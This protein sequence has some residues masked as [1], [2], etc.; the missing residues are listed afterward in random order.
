MKKSTKSNARTAPKLSMK[1]KACIAPTFRPPPGLEGITLQ[2]PPGFEK[3]LPISASP[4]GVPKVSP[5]G[6][7]VVPKG[8]ENIADNTVQISNMPKHIAN[9]QMLEA[10]LQQAQL[11][12]LV[13][14]SVTSFNGLCGE[15]RV[16]LTNKD[17]A[18]RC[19][20]H[21]NGRCWGGI[22]I[23][24]K[25]LA[26][27]SATKSMSPDAPVF[28]PTFV[29]SAKAPEFNPVPVVTKD[30]RFPISMTSEASTDDG[31]SASDDDKESASE[32]STQRVH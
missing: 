30:V 22:V 26:S 7:T 1:S 3:F 9:K 13:L 18:L 16:T 4:S 14:S 25:L 2:P 8:A 12:K 24:A 27:S 19:A 20:A 15:A 32:W 10:I 21:F 31:E 11:D 6:A 5:E 28:V 23:S 17:A 29:L